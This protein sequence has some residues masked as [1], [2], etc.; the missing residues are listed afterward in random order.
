[1]AG[2]PAQPS[3]SRWAWLAHAARRSTLRFR[4]RQPCSSPSAAQVCPP[5]K[6]SASPYST[7]CRLCPEG[8]F[9]YF[10]G[11]DACRTCLPGTFA[12]SR[13]SLYCDICPGGRTTLGE[14]AARC[15]IAVADLKTP[16]FVIMLSFGVLLSG[17]SLGAVSRDTTG[18][19]ASSEGIVAVLVRSDTASALNVSLEAVTIGG[20]RQISRRRLL[21]NVSA[22]VPFNTEDVAAA[23]TRDLSAGECTLASALPRCFWALGACSHL[24]A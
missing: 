12:P 5:G 10:W 22:A 8:S 1:M 24:S 18:I 23:D 11:A 6:F 15:D 4:A 3:V 17:A 2:R 7:G 13:G 14:G 9:S 19:N 20:V 21:V 16:E